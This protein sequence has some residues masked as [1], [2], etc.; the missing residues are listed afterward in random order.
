MATVHEA[1]EELQDSPC[2]V[3]AKEPAYPQ[4]FLDD[5]YSFTAPVCLDQ[6]CR[7][8]IAGNDNDIHAELI[9]TG[10]ALQLDLPRS[11]SDAL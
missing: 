7:A 10:H 11:E 3:C 8:I 2:V 1:I 4:V 6:L 9:D 5:G